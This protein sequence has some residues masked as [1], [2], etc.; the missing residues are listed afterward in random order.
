MSPHMK[1]HLHYLW[2]KELER[3]DRCPDEIR[4]NAGLWA[5][6]MCQMALLC[7]GLFR[8]L[9][10]VYPCDIVPDVR[11]LVSLPNVFMPRGRGTFMRYRAARYP[12]VKYVW[13][14]GRLIHDCFTVDRFRPASA[15]G[16]YGWDNVGVLCPDCQRLKWQH[17]P[18][19]DYRPP[20]YKRQIEAFLQEKYGRQ[21]W[22]GEQN[23]S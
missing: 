9:V 3:Q 8:V 7:D 15:G 12:E 13:V 21:L 1:A 6:W 16:L 4:R 5:Q 17:W 14:C 10:P 2:Y 19:I 23:S 20:E 18:W 22:L 11:Q